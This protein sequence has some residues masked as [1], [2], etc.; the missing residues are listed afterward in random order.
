ME[1]QATKINRST[2]KSAQKLRQ[3][4]SAL[5]RKLEIDFINS[6]DKQKYD[7]PFMRRRIRSNEKSLTSSSSSGSSDL[8]D[9][10]ELNGLL[11]QSRNRLENTNALRIRRHLLRPEDY[12]R[13]D[14]ISNKCNCN[15]EII[16]NSI[17]YEKNLNIES[18]S[19]AIMHAIY[20]LCYFNV[21]GACR[22]SDLIGAILFVA[23]II[24]WILV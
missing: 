22:L 4:T 9:E 20:Q 13:F 17:L 18:T 3:S 19:D 2:S 16:D 14:Q 1:S 10:T 24:Y 15:L 12:V 23:F 21:A 8:E 11:A 6:L 5:N 7:E